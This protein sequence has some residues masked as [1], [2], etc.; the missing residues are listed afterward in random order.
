MT[1]TNT[2]SAFPPLLT[3]TDVQHLLRRGRTAAYAATRTAGFPD[4]VIVGGNYLW[5]RDEVVAWVLAQR[6]TTR[7]KAPALTTTPAA[8]C[9]AT[10]PADRLPTPRPAAKRKAV[11]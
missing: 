6:A 1:T 8:N 5:V 11:R 4:A 2:F 9:A 10:I 7:T 3:I